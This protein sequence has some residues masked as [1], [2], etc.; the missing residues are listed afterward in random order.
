MAMTNCHDA[1]PSTSDQTTGAVVQIPRFSEYTRN[2][3]INFSR[4]YHRTG[5]R[6]SEAIKQAARDWR[7]ISPDERDRFRRQAE[8]A[9]YR[10]RTRNRTFNRILKLLN[11][12]SDETEEDHNNPDKIAK[13]TRM[14][15]RWKLRSYRDVIL[16][17]TLPPGITGHRGRLRKPL[18]QMYG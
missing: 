3:F 2:P 7:E 16:G 9:P 18:P 8:A 14:I 17:S 13:I 12:A 15:E 11:S 5:L 4:S 1:I 6:A 10:M